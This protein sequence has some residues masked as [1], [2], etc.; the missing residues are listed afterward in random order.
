MKT[1]DYYDLTFVND[2]KKYPTSSFG[3]ISKCSL[4]GKIYALKKFNNAK[5]LKGKKRKL[6]MLEKIQ[7][8]HLLT[9]K[10][11]V[12]KENET[13]MYLCDYSDGIELFKIKE[14]SLFQKLTAL[15]QAKEA[16]LSMH[17]EKI[18]HLQ[19]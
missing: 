19:K 16:L 17:K 18:I 6:S 7:N 5:Y 4:E 15:K 9:P 13:N 11:W 2:E 3:K 10:Y 1:I 12:K 8:N 14:Y